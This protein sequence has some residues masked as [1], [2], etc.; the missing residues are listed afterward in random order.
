M[1]A[2]TDVGLV[3]ATIADRY[4]LVELLGRGGMGDVYRAL[5]RELDDAVAL[6]IVRDEVARIPGV[7]ARFRAEVKLAR[8]VTHN[9][10]ARTFEL[11]HADGLTFFTME[12]VQGVSLADRLTRGAIPVGEALAVAAALCDALAAAH[13]VGVIHRDLKPANVLLADDGRVVLTDFGVATLVAADDVVS[14][15]TPRYMAPEQAR[16]EA[17]TPAVDVYALGLVL[18]E[19]VTGTPAF[20]GGVGTV[21]DAKQDPSWAPTGLAAI[22]PGLRAIIARAIAVAPAERWP[23][24]GRLA[25]ALGADPQVASSGA[26]RVGAASGRDLPT[27]VILPP[28]ADG[29]AG[30]LIYGLQDELLRRLSRRARLRLLRRGQ[31]EGTPGVVNVELAGGERATI[32]AW[33]A[34]RADVVTVAA[35]LE[36][37][38][39]V[40]AAELA[41]RLV[42]TTVGAGAER[43]V[44]DPPLPAA[45]RGLLWRGRDLGR[46]DGVSRLAAHAEFAAAAALAPRD[47]RIMAGLAIG[48][49][50]AAFF[51]EPTDPQQMVRA[52]AYATAAI[53]AAPHE[54]EAQLAYGRVRFHSGDAVAAAGH[55]RAAIARAPY[56]AEAHEWLGRLLLEAG[57]LVDGM[58]RVRDV[59]DMD[60]GLEMPRWDLARAYALE[61]QWAEYEAHV[62]ELERRGASLAVRYA[63]RLRTAGWRGDLAE[64]AMIRRE[65]DRSAAG[66]L[67]ER[68][69]ILAVTDAMLHGQWAAMRDRVVATITAPGAGSSRRRAFLGQLVAEASAGFGDLDTAATMLA[70]AVEHGLIDRHWLERC[71]SLA[72]LRGDPRY[73]PLHRVVV[74]R[75]DAILDALY[76]DHAARAT[77]DTLLV[78][79]DRS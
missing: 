46:I 39:L 61:G 6:K 49:V 32:T 15:G 3:G 73:P 45:A 60:P 18:Y 35:P 28:R 12:L 66:P 77:A 17:A 47:P 76:G 43:G 57:F 69:L 63:S 65:I 25:Q 58:A 71:P 55:F 24:V 78:S 37:D 41:S 79:T 22:E 34:G 33:V 59:L 53:T 38:A 23:D 27:A 20:V 19:M 10:V 74:E 29:D 75:A 40:A 44:D 13:A 68:N 51:S 14:S 64:V 8:R 11:G 30:Y 21:L 2:A 70:F 42:A 16:G 72:R 52:E 4:E 36:V 9:N 56:L 67:F 50:R 62:A 48:E 5:D 7:L 54:A 31:P 1:T 26:S